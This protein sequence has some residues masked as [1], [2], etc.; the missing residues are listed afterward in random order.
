M[1]ETV[2]SIAMPEIVAI[3]RPVDAEFAIIDLALDPEM[4]GWVYEQ[5]RHGDIRWESLY[6]GTDW[7]QNWKSGPVL[8]GLKGFDSSADE[9][10]KVFAQ[11]P[12]GLFINGPGA[13][14]E[15]AAEQLRQHAITELNGKQAAFRFYDPRHLAEL[16]SI[17]TE[18][19]VNSLVRPGEQWI[20]HDSEKWQSFS[21]LKSS[22]ATAP[23]TS[24]VLSQEQ[25][26]SFERLKRLKRARSLASHYQAWVKSSDPET[27]IFD[28]LTAAKKAGLDKVSDQERWLRIALT[29]SSPV[30]NSSA[31]QALATNDQLTPRQ[32]LSNMEKTV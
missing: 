28:H 13:A 12:V 31:W 3:E 15:I 27:V 2:S 17:V 24:I 4:L 25:L 23:A 26:E 21:C 32:R 19:H 5:M 7:Q 1:M 29:L 8:V 20:W 30:Q 9:L 16:L 10:A 14:L 6:Q 11:H 22:D 18:G